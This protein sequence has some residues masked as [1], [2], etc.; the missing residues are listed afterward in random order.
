MNAR[1]PPPSRR[2][3]QA[4]QPGDHMQ[5]DRKIRRIHARGSRC[6]I[7]REMRRD[8][9]QEMALPMSASVKRHEP[10]SS[11][12][13]PASSSSSRRGVVGLVI[14]DRARLR[15]RVGNLSGPAS[16]AHRCL[17]APELKEPP[18]HPLIRELILERRRSRS[19]NLA[20]PARAASCDAGIKAPDE[21][22]SGV[23]RHARMPYIQEAIG[24][25]RPGSATMP[26]VVKSP[27]NALPQRPAAPTE[28]TD[29]HASAVRDGTHQ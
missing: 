28:Q 5:R 1:A 13:R 10:P 21:I 16:A 20:L 8:V 29:R 23:N 12:W 4:Q 18:G 14:F 17:E 9:H 24:S 6:S 27:P 19:A 3:A 11:T 7:N 25:R 15:R 26:L 2:L 22:R